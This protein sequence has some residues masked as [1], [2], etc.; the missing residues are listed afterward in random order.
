MGHVKSAGAR[1]LREWI[2]RKFDG[3][4]SVFATAHGLD[5]VQVARI[6]SGERGSQV[7]ARF[8]WAIEKA[9][10]GKITCAD[11]AGEAA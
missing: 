11:W 7:S 10:K 6:L 1:K 4:V 9:T 3:R 2:D 5:R 8:A